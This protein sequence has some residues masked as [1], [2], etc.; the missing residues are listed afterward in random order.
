MKKQ[1][2]ELSQEHSISALSLMKE[3]GFDRSNLLK[4]ALEAMMRAE[5]EMHNEEA[6][7]FGN[8]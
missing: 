3:R 5:R 6:S 4:M 1:T 8:G 2:L 7:D